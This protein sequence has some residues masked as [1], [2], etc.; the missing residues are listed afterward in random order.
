LGDNY[1]FTDKVLVFII[2]LKQNFLGTIKLGST[3]PNAPLGYGPACKV[4]VSHLDENI[5]ALCLRLNS[6]KS[7]DLRNNAFST[8]TKCKSHE[9]I[10]FGFVGHH[11]RDITRSED[12]C[13][14][15]L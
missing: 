13:I 6:S 4:K 1:I 8:S 3:A 11:C 5:A 2:C 9:K 12:K 14:F 15:Y 7:D 10:Y